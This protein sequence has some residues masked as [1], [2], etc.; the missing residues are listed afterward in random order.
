MYPGHLRMKKHTMPPRR[1]A[2]LCLL[3]GLGDAITAS[4]IIRRLDSGGVAIDVLV[5]LRPVAEYA[6]ALREVRNTYYAPMLTAPQHALGLLK[7]LRDAKY[8]CCIVPFPATRWQYAFVARSV[9]AKRIVIHQYGGL[10]AAIVAARST[11]FVRLRGGHRMAENERIAD[12][13][14]LP[15]DFAKGYLV[16]DVWRSVRIPGVLGIHPGSMLYKGNEARR[17]PFSQFIA[18]IKLQA[19]RSLRRVRVFLGPNEVADAERFSLELAPY[20]VEILQLPLDQ[21]A[22]KLSECEVFVGND[23]GFAHLASGLGVKT[24]ALFGMTNPE[25]AVPLGPAMALRP[26]PCPPCHDEG[27]RDFS[28][29]LGIQYR[30]LQEDL[31]VADVDR[32]VN[33]LF[34]NDG[35]DQV[36]V[37]SGPFTLYGKRWD[38]NGVSTRS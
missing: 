18:L 27:L 37:N 3:P 17:W 9:G 6:E 1:N 31:A 36:P 34:L 20:N 26:S 38:A 35:L 12:A 33:S 13:L 11:T 25:R 19:G 23:A 5:M 29:A 15:P 32:T 30:C 14:D 16:P 2:L 4:S 28:C 21:A 8:D 24:I 7:E 10:S 22:R